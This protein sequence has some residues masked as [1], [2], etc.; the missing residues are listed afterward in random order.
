M[1]QWAQKQAGFTIVELLI[2]VVVIAILA[3]I[4]IVSFSGIQQQAKVTSIVDAA[5]KSQRM[6]MAYIA[7]N[8]TY[9]YTGSSYACITTESTCRRNSGPLANVATFDT[10]MA[11]IG[12][13]PKSTPLATDIRGGITYQYNASRTVDG[14]PAPAVLGYYLPGTNVD[15]GFPVL[16][17]DSTAAVTVSS[18]YTNGNVGSSNTTQCVVSIPGPGV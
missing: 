5:G 2:V 4:T 16:N 18:K 10:E 13:T 11:T 15:C 17:G 12:S 1:K 7:K 9:P 8:G 14:T 3:A 6:I